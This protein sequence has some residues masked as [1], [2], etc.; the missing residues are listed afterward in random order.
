MKFQFSRC[1]S[2]HT[3][4]YQKSLEFYKDIL[5][6]EINNGQEPVELGS[7]QPGRLFLDESDL[8]QPIL[9]FI[10]KDVEA[11]RDHLLKN[12]CSV[13]R[14]EGAGKDCYMQDPFGTIFN[15]WEDSSL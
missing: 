8:N 4:Q 14:W 13:I 15:L 7:D 11:A 10:C 12:G 5:G 1:V 3:D 9:E 6:F 2:V